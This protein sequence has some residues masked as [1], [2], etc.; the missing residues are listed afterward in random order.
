MANNAATLGCKVVL[1]AVF[2]WTGAVVAAESQLGKPFTLDRPKA[3]HEVL[4]SAA[5]NTGKT[6]Q[7]KGKITEVCQMMGCWMALVDPADSTQ[8]IRIEVEDGDI[9]FPK[10]S[11]GKMAVAE[12][13]L[14]K[15][16]LTR[17]E[18]VAKARHEAEEQGRKFDPKSIQHG[19]TYY[20]IHGTGALIVEQ[21]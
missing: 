2:V 13:I 1:T 7:V 18:T 12:G 4:A 9:V 20:E 10:D 6:V 17:D 5:D 19:S 15:Q 3:I 8:T 11:A 16:E 21:K 14:N